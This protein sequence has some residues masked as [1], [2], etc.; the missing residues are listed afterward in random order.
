MMVDKEKKGQVP[1]NIKAARIEGS[2]TINRGQ[3]ISEFG[4]GV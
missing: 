1:I 2:G 4:G 3:L